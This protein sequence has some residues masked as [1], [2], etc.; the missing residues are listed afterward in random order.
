MGKALVIKGA[1]FSTNKI[2]NIS[3]DGIRRFT[4]DKAIG[5]YTGDLKGQGNQVLFTSGESTYYLFKVKRGER[6][7]V[8]KQTNKF[9]VWFLSEYNVESGVSVNMPFEDLP[10]VGKTYATHDYAKY[11]SNS[12]SILAQQDFYI[13]VM[14]NFNDYYYPT[15][16]YATQ[17]YEANR[18]FGRE[19]FEAGV[20]AFIKSKDGGGYMWGNAGIKDA[21]NPGLALY[22]V[23][24]GETIHLTARESAL[25]KFYLFMQRE[26]WDD[27]C[28]IQETIEVPAGETTT[29]DVPKAGMRLG[30]RR[31]DAN[32][33]IF[34]ETP[35][36]TTLT[37]QN[38][39]E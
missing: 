33:N 36:Y 5:T 20:D 38:E 34:P 11:T 16:I 28:I 9:T 14:D 30:V 4:K 19:T 37:T 25:T 18:T 29:Y 3:I 12:L 39:E 32:I 22:N 21:G 7:V 17:S 27:D 23:H 8:D 26:P 2:E 35:P 15:S 1:D 31:R 10:Y 24:Q 13:A 6:L